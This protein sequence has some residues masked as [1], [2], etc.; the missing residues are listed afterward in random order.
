M[1]KVVRKTTGES[2]D[3]YYDLIDDFGLIVSSFQT[4]YGIRLSKDLEN[5]KWDEF[6]D[7]LIGI[8]PETPLGRIVSIRAEKDKEILKHFTKEQRR[9]RSEWRNRGAKEIKKE[10]MD[11]VLDNFKQMFIQMAGK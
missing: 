9:I 4:Q 6:K 1:Y 11:K 10:E 3:P 8:S 5:M 2:E 7:L